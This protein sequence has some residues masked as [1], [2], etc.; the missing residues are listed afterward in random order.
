MNRGPI[1][2]Y[3]V[4]LEAVTAYKK[5]NRNTMSLNNNFHHSRAFFSDLSEASMCGYRQYNGA[6]REDASLGGSGDLENRLEVFFL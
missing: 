4:E 2:I 6:V 5:E 3:L 1:F